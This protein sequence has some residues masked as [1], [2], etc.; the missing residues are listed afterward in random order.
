MEYQDLMY[1][2]YESDTDSKKDETDFITEIKEKFPN[3]ELKN[4]YDNIKGYRQEVYLEKN[5]SDN[6]WA[7]LI[8][9]GWLELS[10]TGQL[11][12]MSKREKDRLMKYINL[13]KSQYPQNFKSEALS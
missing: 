9:Y 12:L 10:L 6:Y 7:W 1:F 2:G 3:V 5:E 4:A 13:A 8:A 11:M